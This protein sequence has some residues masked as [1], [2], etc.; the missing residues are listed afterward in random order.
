MNSSVK[1]YPKR[2]K[3]GVLS[4]IF[5]LILSAQTLY[6][7][8][9]FV[10]PPPTSVNTAVGA[11][12]CPPPTLRIFLPGIDGDWRLWWRWWGGRWRYIWQVIIVYGAISCLTS[13]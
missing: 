11:G 10:N 5:H 6:P 12:V 3:N 7:S 13:H 8:P 1:V 2:L 9:F 4:S